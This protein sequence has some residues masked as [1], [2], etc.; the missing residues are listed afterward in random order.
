MAINERDEIQRLLHGT[1]RGTD[2]LI[3]IDDDLGAGL[4]H[5]RGSGLVKYR[6]HDDQRQLGDG[7]NAQDCGKADTEAGKGPRPDGHDEALQLYGQ[8]PGD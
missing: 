1:N 3:G 5:L 6:R 8:E 7:A 2:R 4:F